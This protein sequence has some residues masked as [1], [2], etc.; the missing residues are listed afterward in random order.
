M[1]KGKTNE[2]LK[3]ALKIAGL[4]FVTLLLLSVWSVFFGRSENLGVKKGG[5]VMIHEEE[6]DVSTI[7]M[8]QLMSD[9]EG[10]MMER[11][12]VYDLTNETI[13]VSDSSVVA[14]KKI[15]K[16]GS[17]NLK[18]ENT[19]EASKEVSMIAKSQGGEVFSTNFYER[20]KGQKSG[21]VT[22]KVP[23]LKFEETIEKLKTIATQVVSESTTGQDVTEQYADLQIQLRNKKAEE[24][25]FVGILERAGKIDDVLAV[26]KQIARVRSEIERL[27]GRIRFMESQ[28]D[29]STI[30]VSLSED[31]E[32]SP[33]RE[34]WR[35]WEV[36]KA[37][38]REL[39]ENMQG[40][41]DGLIRFVIVGIPA[42]IPF[43]LIIWAVYWIGKRI[44]KKI[45][46]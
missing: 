4:I 44:V 24:D 13:A 29:M 14:D 21:S 2:S 46:K 3:K 40:F 10:M 19:E 36:I 12:S 11:G 42:L 1:K 16:N 27:E 31:T 7:G 39:V 17:L 25:S 20:V 43:V 45:T 33:V 38:S 5:N 22:I 23:V 26:T 32:I 30:T 6:S 41:V 15:I 9:S 37:S 34:G 8:P 28:T 18:V 35:P